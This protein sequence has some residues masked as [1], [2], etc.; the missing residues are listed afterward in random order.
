MQNEHNGG[1]GARLAVEGNEGREGFEPDSDGQIGSDI[2]EK[3]KGI[4]AGHLDVLDERSLGRAFARAFGRNRLEELRD[5]PA[6]LPRVDGEERIGDLYGVHVIED[7]PVRE[8]AVRADVH[9]AA[10]DAA[11]RHRGQRVHLRPILD[12]D[13]SAE[14][15]RLPVCQ[16]GFGEPVVG[17]RA[18][19]AG[20]AEDAPPRRSDCIPEEITPRNARPAAPATLAAAVFL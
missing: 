9:V 5:A 16:L 20:E 2:V 1:K 7:E 4:L 15:R 14:E 6:A 11:E 17:R 12:G 18:R 19:E 10:T 3:G 8:R 13:A